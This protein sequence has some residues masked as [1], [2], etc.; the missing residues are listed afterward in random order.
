MRVIIETDFELAIKWLDKAEEPK[1]FAC[2]LLRMCWDL[3]DRSWDI[4]MLH[5]YSKG[6]KATDFLAKMACSQEQS[7]I[8]QEN[9]LSSLTQIFHEDILGCSVPR[10]IPNMGILVLCNFLSYTPPFDKFF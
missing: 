9:L 7:M 5:T 1:A 3:I 4:V 6:N 2:N 8:V 10:L